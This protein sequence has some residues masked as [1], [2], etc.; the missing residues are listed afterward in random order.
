M[1]QCFP[2]T[3]Q[4]K[5]LW[6]FLRM[7]FLVITGFRR[8][9]VGDPLFIESASPV[10]MQSCELAVNQYPRRRHSMNRICF[11]FL[12]VLAA[13]V[14]SPP[15]AVLGQQK[16]VPVTKKPEPEMKKTNPVQ[17]YSSS[18]PDL[19]FFVEADY[20]GLK[21]P[22]VDAVYRTIE[23]NLSLPKG[24]DFKIPYFVLT[25]IRF[26]PSDT[27]AIQAEF[28]GSVLKTAKDTSTNFLQVYYAGG[29]Y[30][31]N[32]PLGVVSVFAGGGLGYMWLA[33][34]RT[35]IT[36]PGVARVNGRLMQLHAMFGVEFY[37]HSGVS[38]ALEG[39]YT[40]ATTVSP[41]RSDLDMTIK[42]MSVGVRI[43]IPLIKSPGL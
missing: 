18:I 42:G 33:T 19:S 27:H 14:S 26:S 23:R 7:Q 4:R 35:Y 37:T 28:G 21:L 16:A 5:T 32:L 43:G 24:N 29:S 11:I 15:N 10:F 12:V 8:V 25:G 22:E 39:Q 17:N 41:A 34:E 1:G 6:T 38:F 13:L 36:R 9:R 3:V 31:Y 40:Y 2:V 20:Y 30:L